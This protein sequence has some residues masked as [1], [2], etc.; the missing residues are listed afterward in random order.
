VDIAWRPI[1]EGE[2]ATKAQACIAQ[3]GAALD[4]SEGAAPS[5][6]SDPTLADGHA[7][8]TLF[9]AD[10]ERQKN[11][12]NN[13]RRQDVAGSVLATVLHDI[14]DRW[15]T[16]YLYGG[17]VGVAWALSYM[18][19][20]FDSALDLSLQELDGQL[21]ELCAAADSALEESDLMYGFIGIGVYALERWPSKFTSDC[22]P[23][24]IERLAR[25]TWSELGLAHGAAG[26]IAFL[27]AAARLDSGWRAQI[28]PVVKQHIDKLLRQRLPANETTGAFPREIGGGPTRLGWCH[29][30]TSIAV[31]LLAAGMQFENRDWY[32][33]AI[34]L[35]VS[36]SERP[37][38]LSGVVDAGLCH[39]AAGLGHI[40]NRLFQASGEERLAV[41][42]RDWFSV[43]LSM[44]ARM[45]AD[46]IAGFSSWSYSEAL[47]RH[48]KADHGF[49]TGVAGIGLALM[50]AI[51]RHEPTWDRVLLLSSGAR[52][53]TRDK[54]GDR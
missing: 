26:V 48:W 16:P 2:P 10:R 34:E 37:R 22:I 14:D 8:I 24:L 41:A 45:P 12:P 9:I 6:D 11:A 23:L 15:R 47:G 42:A 25:P 3:I 44:P 54:S 19:N 18:S 27:S 29:G 53:Q 30:D 40:F 50:A 28:R 7:G 1:L 39:G 46:G 52:G 20:E 13:A 17:V 4:L 35:A 43:A 49:H 51:G 33:A 36:A 31:A 38:E 5:S 21:I 32:S